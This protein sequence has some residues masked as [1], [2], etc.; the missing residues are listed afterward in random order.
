MTVKAAPPGWEP[1]RIEWRLDGWIIDPNDETRIPRAVA[2][3]MARA[4]TQPDAVAVIRA[5][6]Q[7]RQD[8]YDRSKDQT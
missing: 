7:A 2:A 4:M 6:M 8:A 3:L 5:R 1:H